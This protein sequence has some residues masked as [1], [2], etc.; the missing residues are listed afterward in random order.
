MCNNNSS[1]SNEQSLSFVFF[2]RPTQKGRRKSSCRKKGK[3]FSSMQVMSSEE[4]ELCIAAQTLAALPA[5]AAR[6]LLTASRS[7]TGWLCILRQGF[8]VCCCSRQFISCV[9]FCDVCVLGTGLKVEKRRKSFWQRCAFHVTFWAQRAALTAWKL[10]QPM[11]QKLRFQLTTCF[12]LFESVQFDVSCSRRSSRYK[13]KAIQSRYPSPIM[14]SHCP[15]WSCQVSPQIL[16]KSVKC[17][18]ILH[19]GINLPRWQH[20]THN[21]ITFP[22]STSLSWQGLHP[23]H[24]KCI[25]FR[26]RP[27]TLV[28]VLDHA[29]T[30]QEAR[31][32]TS[33]PPPACQTTSRKCDPPSFGVSPLIVQRERERARLDDNNRS[34][35]EEKNRLEEG[36]SVGLLWTKESLWW[37]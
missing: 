24:L 34:F 10:A 30:K 4:T 31:V 21:W 36:G 20:R 32:P 27:W 33:T 25:I 22:S 7:L 12:P 8:F 18:S 16:H 3:N 11:Q 5:A 14:P 19:P 37:R 23:L 15:R 17:H 6:G 26:K 2:V 35:P 13:K 28:V 9:L 1:P 29:G